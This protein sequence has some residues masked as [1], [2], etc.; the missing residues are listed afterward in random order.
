MSLIVVEIATPNGTE[1]VLTEDPDGVRAC[2]ESFSLN[3]P[4]SR[5]LAM[6]AV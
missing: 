3:R 2:L 1:W 5:S 4:E 6:V